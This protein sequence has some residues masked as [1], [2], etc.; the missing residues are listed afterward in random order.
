[1][2]SSAI[3]PPDREFTVGR[4]F[5]LWLP[6]AFTFLLMSGSS[7]IVTAGINWMGG[8]STASLAAFCDAFRISIFLH[9]PTFVVRDIAIR[10]IRDR[11][12]YK[13][14]LV[15]V[16]GV[17]VLCSALEFLV[18]LTSV[19][20]WLLGEIVLTPPNLVALTKQA[21]LPFAALPVLLALRGIHQ[22][23]HIRGETASWVGFGTALRLLAIAAFS[24]LVGPRL[25]LD[26]AVMGSSAFLIG[27]VV[28]SSVNLVS[29]LRKSPVLRVRRADGPEEGYGDLARFAVPLMI[30]NVTGVLFQPIVSRIA[31]GGGDPATSKASLQVLISWVW[32]FS[33]SLFAMQ[34]MTIAHGA[35]RRRLIVLLR[36]GLLVAA[37]FCGVFLTVALVPPVRDFVLGSVFG[38][39]DP[40]LHRFVTD[41]LPIAIVFPVLVLARALLRG[42][43]VRS[44]RTGWVFATTAA[45][46]VTLLALDRSG[47]LATIPNGSLPAVQAWI[48]ALVV[49]AGFSAVALAK[50]G[51]TRVFAEGRGAAAEPIPEGVASSAR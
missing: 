29:A 27:L 22:G 51:F 47:L 32:F 2:T 18:A 16:L 30:A 37:I 50:I 33:S 45:G 25:G 7:P 24:F 17:A 9:A 20:D 43:I 14:N 19:G 26:G 38:V 23:V 8:D 39:G 41:V 28:E 34:A 46:L 12:S 21:L 3:P 11:R 40:L 15:F 1:V 48:L 31:G 10:S 49:E 5:R 35:G 13:R 44:G 42:M 6:L 36:F 4:L